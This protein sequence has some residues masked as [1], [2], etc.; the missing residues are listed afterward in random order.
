MTSRRRKYFKACGRIAT[1][2]LMCLIRPGLRGITNT[3]IIY[4][5]MGPGQDARTQAPYGPGPSLS[6]ARQVI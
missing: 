5:F 3:C 6:L 4:T 1:N 2:T